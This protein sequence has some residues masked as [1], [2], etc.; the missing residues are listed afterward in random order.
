MQAAD[1]K[2]TSERDELDDIIDR[3]QMETKTGRSREELRALVHK[4]ITCLNIAYCLADVIDWLIFDTD[5]T[6]GPF[7]ASLDKNDKRMFKQLKRTLAS[8]RQ[9]ARD[10]TRGVYHHEDGEKFQGESDWWYNIIRLIEDRTGDDEL[11]TR[12]VINWLVTMPSVLNM[13]DVRTKDF[14]RLID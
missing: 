13:F 7:G 3:F 5:S 10:I 9:Q 8:A 2:T 1:T 4:G 6:L 14:K 11:K 12:Q